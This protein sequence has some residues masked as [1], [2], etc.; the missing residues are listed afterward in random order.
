MKSYFQS[1]P[2]ARLFFLVVSLNIWLGIWLTGFG[3]AHGW[4]YLPAGFL[5]FAAMSGFCPGMVMTR[6]LFKEK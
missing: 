5:L 2:A 4:L 6:W 1:S 3:V